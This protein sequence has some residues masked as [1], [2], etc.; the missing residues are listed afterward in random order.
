[1]PDRRRDPSRLRLVRFLVALVRDRD[2]AY[3]RR[4]ARRARENLSLVLGALG[5]TYIRIRP[6]ED[7]GG[8]APGAAC[9]RFVLGA[10]PAGLVRVNLAAY[11]LALPD[12]AGRAVIDAGTNEGAGAALFAAHAAS[13]VAFDVST[14]AIAAA[15]ARYTRPGLTFETHDATKP[16]PVRD[17]SVDVVFSSEVIEHL[18]NGRAF[19]ESAARA[20]KPGGLLLLKTP[21]D[22][23]NR[24]ENRLNEHHVNVYTVHRLRS[25]VQEFFEVLSLEGLTYDLTVDR[26]TEERPDPLP[27]DQAP[28]R[29][30][31]PITVDREVVLTLRVTP[32]RMLLPGPEVPEYLWLRAVRRGAATSQEPPASS[33]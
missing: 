11:H 10:Q 24:L 6:Y 3:A 19:L 13:V 4:L 23:F 14:E 17:G 8:V 18:A 32:R 2:F 12:V 20:L 15:R 27:P 21:N 22:D 16:F 30:G 9:E 25:E 31:D 5:A 7:F 29:F 26:R 1:M 33:R 28:Y